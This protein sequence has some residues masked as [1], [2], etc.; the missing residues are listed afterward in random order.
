MRK[1]FKERK[2]FQGGNY[3][4]KYGRQKIKFKSQVQNQ[5]CELEISKIKGFHLLPLHFILL[6]KPKTQRIPK[7]MP[8]GPPIRVINNIR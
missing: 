5:F 8:P 4:R 7:V 3:M 1:L 6:Q 2:L